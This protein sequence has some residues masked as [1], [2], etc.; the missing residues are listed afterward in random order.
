[1]TYW[2]NYDWESVDKTNWQGA[3]S[4]LIGFHGHHCYISKFHRTEGNANF[5]DFS[6]GMC[7]GQHY[8]MNMGPVVGA[9]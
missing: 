6:S 7:F 3:K 8:S 1:M 2:A 4:E 9:L 5:S